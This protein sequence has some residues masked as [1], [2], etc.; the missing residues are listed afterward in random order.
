MKTRPPLHYFYSLIAT[1][2]KKKKLCCR[3]RYIYIYIY[4]LRAYQTYTHNKHKTRNCLVPQY[5]CILIRHVST[6]SIRG[7]TVMSNNI[8]IYIDI[9]SHGHIDSK[10]IRLMSIVELILTA[11]PLVFIALNLLM[12]RVFAATEHPKKIAIH[13]KRKARKCGCRC[14]KKYDA[15]KM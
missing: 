11:A 14:L 7:A 2:C 4:I 13:K 15:T 5:S 6:T 10:H 12:Y 9:I 3:T 1:H 8:Y